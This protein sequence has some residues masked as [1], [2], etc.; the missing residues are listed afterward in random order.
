MFHCFSDQT[1]S[2]RALEFFASFDFFYSNFGKNA[3]YTMISSSISK[4]KNKT[5][6]KVPNLRKG[7]QALSKSENYSELSKPS[8]QS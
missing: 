6:P 2:Y 5:L 4:Q 7:K 1:T 8:F 3:V